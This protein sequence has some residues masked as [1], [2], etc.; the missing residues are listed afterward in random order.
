MVG[1]MMRILGVEIIFD[2]ID[3]LVESNLWF[4][5]FS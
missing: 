4:I 2:K 5:K 1:F 3:F